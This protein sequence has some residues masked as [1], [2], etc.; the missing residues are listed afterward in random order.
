LDCAKIAD[1]NRATRTGV[2]FY[3][4]GYKPGDPDI[5]DESP[6][7]RNR[8]LELPDAVDVLV[9]GERAGGHTCSRH[10]SRRFPAINTATDRA[11]ARPELELG[12]ADG[13]AC[14]TVEMFETVRVGREACPAKA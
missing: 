12:Q 2:Q 3:L 10:S 5:L 4:N 11:P 9:V 1:G 8:P 14:R 7:A 6:A 13:V